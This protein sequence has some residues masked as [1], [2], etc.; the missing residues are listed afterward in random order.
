MEMRIQLIGYFR[1]H[2]PTLVTLFLIP[3]TPEMPFGNRKIYFGGSFQFSIV[4][5]K[6]MTS[7]ET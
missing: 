3:N 7:L 6:K 4:T 1:T 5:I 2:F